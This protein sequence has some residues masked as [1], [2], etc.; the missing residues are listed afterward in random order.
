YY[1]PEYVPSYY[2][3]SYYPV[4]ASGGPSMTAVYAPRPELP[5]LGVGLF[6]GGV[7][8]QDSAGNSQHDSS[9]VGILG[10]LRLGNGGLLVEGELGKTSYDVNGTSNVR[11]DR[12]LGGSLIYE[13]GAY[14]ALAP[15]VLGGIGVQQASVNG[16]YSTTQDFAE[17]GVG[18]RWAV[19]PHFHLTADIRAGSRSTVANDTMP[20]STLGT[21]RS[22]APPTTDSGNSEDYTRARLAAI[23]YF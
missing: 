11:V 22:I 2:S 12:R 23:L 4:E 5:K 18:L 1:Y 10:R 8:T 14:N 19:T 3:A 17:V 21:A 16:D 7:S 20:A 9:D 15:Y 6:A 13:I